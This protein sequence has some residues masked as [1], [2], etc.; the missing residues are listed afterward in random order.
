MGMGIAG[1]ALL[2]LFAVWHLPM[3]VWLPDARQYA[4]VEDTQVLWDLPTKSTSVIT[5]Y[6]RAIR[7]SSAE[8][9]QNLYEFT[10]NP[11]LRASACPNIMHRESLSPSGCDRIGSFQGQSVYAMNRILPSGMTEYY[12][13]LGHT[14]LYIQSGGDGG[15]SLRFID[16]LK[17]LP[18]GQAKAYLANNDVRTGKIRDKQRAEQEATERHNASAYTRLDFTPALP[19]ALPAGWQLTEAKPPIQLDGP[20]ADHPAMVNVGYIKSK[21]QYLGLHAGKLSNFQLGQACG[22]SPGY[23]MENLSCYKVSGTDYYEAV[24]YDDL[25]DFVRY[26]YRPVGDSLVISEIVVYAKDNQRP[27]WP[28][29]LAQAQDAITTSAQPIDKNSLKGST[30]NRLY[31]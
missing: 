26:L 6:G 22:P 20:D 21:T 10:A 23:S 28:T 30:Y 18:R 13:R 15:R 3:T 8:K 12:V 2:Y 19:S 11:L 14:F 16:T 7:Y 5:P 25:N 24:R 4:N 1:I 17:S 29:E 31:Y 9:W 27:A